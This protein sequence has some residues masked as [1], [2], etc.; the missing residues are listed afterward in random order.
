MIKLKSNLDNISDEEATNMKRK[1][2]KLYNNKKIPGL[3]TS[4]LKKT[5]YEIE[6]AKHCNV[7][8][9]CHVCINAKTVTDRKY[10]HQ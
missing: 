7:Y 4:A 9:G 5:F 2:F 10:S 1:I 8:S 6:K 3:F